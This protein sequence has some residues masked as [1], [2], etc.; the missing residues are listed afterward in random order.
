MMA[1]HRMAERL[2]RIRHGPDIMSAPR[3]EEFEGQ[4]KSAI[5]ACEARVRSGMILRSGSFVGYA[6]DR[7]EQAA[8]LWN[9]LADFWPTA[10][11]WIGMARRG[12]LPPIPEW[13]RDKPSARRDWI[14]HNLVRPW[15][16]T[17]RGRLP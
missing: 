7:A 11:E 14:R 4:W 1:I 2:M 9:R 6:S 16:S 3:T 12:L 8:C 5:S 17:H 15:I 13:I 10:S